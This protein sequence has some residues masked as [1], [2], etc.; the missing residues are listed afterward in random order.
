MVAQMQDSLKKAK[1]ARS[2]KSLYMGEAEKLRTM[3]NQYAKAF[4]LNIPE[5]P[6]LENMEEW[7]AKALERERQEKLAQDKRDKEA[8]RKWLRG[9]THSAPRTRIP[10]VRVYNGEV[11]TSWGIRVPLRRAMAL[12]RLATHCK[13]CEHEYRPR[14]RQTID[15]YPIDLID[16]A[17]SIRAGCHFLPYSVQHEA[18]KLAGLAR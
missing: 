17:G 10:Y 14:K 18:A 3:A 8:I 16:T 12:Y 15:G 7:V 6:A 1:R 13:A 9:E 5:L 2:Y 11:Q 4:A